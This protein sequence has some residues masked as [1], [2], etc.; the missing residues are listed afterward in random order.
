MVQKEDINHLQEHLLNKRAELDIQVDIT[1]RLGLL[2]LL[3]WALPSAD[4]IA[5][6]DRIHIDGD[7]LTCFLDIAPALRTDQI[8]AVGPDDIR[9]PVHTALGLL[10][11]LDNC[12]EPKSDLIRSRHLSI[13]CI[14]CHLLE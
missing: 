7:T 11:F 2:D 13:V 10:Y 14:F 8:A 4:R 5:N 9:F 1:Y 3:R 12:A 6:S